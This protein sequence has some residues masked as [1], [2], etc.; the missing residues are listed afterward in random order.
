MSAPDSLPIHLRLLEIGLKFASVERLH[1]GELQ[2]VS[3]VEIPS[4]SHRVKVWVKNGHCF[5]NLWSLHLNK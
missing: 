2:T 1:I 3:V 5:V 4:K